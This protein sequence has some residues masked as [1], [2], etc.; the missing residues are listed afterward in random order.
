MVIIT[1]AQTSK[2]F[3]DDMKLH[4]RETYGDSLNRLIEY[5]KLNNPMHTDSIDAPKKH[6]NSIEETPG[7]GFVVDATASDKDSE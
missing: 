5:W 4:P 1:I 7:G 3:L 2:T 6:L